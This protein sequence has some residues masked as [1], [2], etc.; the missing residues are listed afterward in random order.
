MCGIAGCY[1]RRDG[2]ALTR[3]MTTLLGHRGPD[4]EGIY[5]YERDGITASLGHRRLSI[6]DLSDAAA[7]PFAK[8]GLTLTYNGELYNY[9]DLR[10]ELASHGVRFCSTS[11][12][13]VVLE[14]WRHWG[15]GWKPS[16]GTLSGPPH[17]TSKRAASTSY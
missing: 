4:G 9:R 16:R 1:Q 8:G 11:D 15:P 7:Q 12:P 6:I 13:E 17:T 10:R 2:P 14:A 3:A 5:D